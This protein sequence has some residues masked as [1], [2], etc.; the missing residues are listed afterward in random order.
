MRV[1]WR[2]L[3]KWIG[4]LIG[5]QV[6]LWISGG[7]VMSL[8]PIEMVRGNHL[9][10]AL[11]I[12]TPSATGSYVPDLSRWQQVE[13]VSRMGR[14]VIKLSNGQ[15]NIAYVDPLTGG[16]LPVVTESE[17]RQIAVQRY[18]GQGQIIDVQLIEQIPHEASRLAAPMFRV[19]FDDWINTTL[20]IGPSSGAVETVRS[21]L[22]R[23]YDFF[24]MLHIMDFDERKD[25]N[26]ALLIVAAL[27]AL[28]FTITGFVLLFSSLKR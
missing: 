1:T 10:H 21:D 22:W 15:K 28:L 7:V 14:S 2:K 23:F 3:H 8:I 9:L 11:P 17:V 25:F 16:A 6:L 5:L 12:G 19:Q 4:W 24:W 13:W 26:N 20:Y 27:I 18:A